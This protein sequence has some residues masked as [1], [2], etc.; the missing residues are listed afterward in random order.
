MVSGQNMDA[1]LENA[2]DIDLTKLEDRDRV[3]YEQQRMRLYRCWERN[4]ASFEEKLTNTRQMEKKQDDFKI[5]NDDVILVTDGDF[6]AVAFSDRIHNYL[7]QSM[8]NSAFIK[9]LDR[10]ICYHP[11]L[12]CL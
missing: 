1:N 11:L 7:S 9:L 12:N 3:E 8:R 4:R 5:K 6:P 10:A 2:S